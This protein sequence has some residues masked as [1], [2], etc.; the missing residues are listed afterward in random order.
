MLTFLMFVDSVES[1]NT[2]DAMIGLPSSALANSSCTDIKNM[3][4]R[5][6]VVQR[7]KAQRLSN[8]DN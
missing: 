4:Q 8:V 2:C 5:T 1:H 3:N 7:A 6:S